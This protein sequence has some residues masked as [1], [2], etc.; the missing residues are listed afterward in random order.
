MNK[1]KQHKQAAMSVIRAYQALFDTDNGKIVLEDL[2][3]YTRPNHKMDANSHAAMCVHEGLRRVW[4]HINSKL[5]MDEAS[6]SAYLN[7]YE[8]HDYE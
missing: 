8:E 2:E 3:R 1:K 5:D 6:I 4:L 7:R